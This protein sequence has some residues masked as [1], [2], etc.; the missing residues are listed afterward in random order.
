[1]GKKLHVNAIFFI[2]FDLNNNNNNNDKKEKRRRY[3]E[4]AGA[5]SLRV[6][7]TSRTQRIRYISANPGSQN[8]KSE[9]N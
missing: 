2:T 9:E 4:C 5:P 3:Y 7:V 8:L 1:M 6:V